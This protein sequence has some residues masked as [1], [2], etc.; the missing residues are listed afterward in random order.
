[1]LA[2]IEA[3]RHLIVGSDEADAFVPRKAFGSKKSS[4]TIMNP[5]ATKMTN[6]A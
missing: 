2:R 3:A 1:V 5:L 6:N 4:P